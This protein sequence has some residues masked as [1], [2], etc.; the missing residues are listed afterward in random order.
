[1]CTDWGQSP[2]TCCPSQ[3]G[4]KDPLFDQQ[5]M[6]DR[7]Q[8]RRH[9]SGCSCFCKTVFTLTLLLYR[10][11]I[12]YIPAASTIYLP[13]R[14]GNNEFSEWIKELKNRSSTNYLMNR[15]HSMGNVNSLPPSPRYQGQTR[16]HCTTCLPRTPFLVPNKISSFSNIKNSCLSTTFTEEGENVIEVAKYENVHGD[17]FTHYDGD[18]AVLD[19]HPGLLHDP[20]LG[21]K[22][23][24][25]GNLFL[26]FYYFLY[27]Y[28]LYLFLT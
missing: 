16:T 2:V 18:S 13:K 20:P 1:M 15:P 24:L 9:M 3:S 28:L 26:Y 8:S 10:K 19:V 4:A 25:R 12:Q 11:H 14:K 17:T 21:S 22:C 27:F 23:V 7:T 5:S 6:C